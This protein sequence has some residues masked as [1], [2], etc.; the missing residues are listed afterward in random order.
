MAFRRRAVEGMSFDTAIGPSP[1]NPAGGEELVFIRHLRRRGG[2]VIWLPT[3]RVKHYVMPSRT[4]LEYLK[5]FTLAKGREEVLLQPPS[6]AE[7]PMMM[8][9]PRWLW[10]EWLTTTL[11]Y[12]LSKI[13]RQTSPRRLR[14]GPPANE[15]SSRRVRS[16]TWLRESLFLWGMIT[17]YRSPRRRAAR[18]IAQP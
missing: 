13:G 14:S 4:T 15:S 1:D 17:G 16:L 7:A 10:R 3:M 18:S 11:R 6:D 12:W 8:G 2:I 9:V 5:S